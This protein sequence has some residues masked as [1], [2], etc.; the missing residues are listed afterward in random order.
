MRDATP[1]LTIPDSAFTFSH[2]PAGATAWAGR[3]R[4]PGR[5]RESHDHLHLAAH[6]AAAQAVLPRRAAEHEG[7]V[8]DEE[9]RQVPMRSP[10]VTVHSSRG[11]SVIEFAIVL[12][13][14]LHRDA[15]RRRRSATRSST[16]TSSPSSTREGS[17][18][19]SR[20][21]SLADAAA[22]LKSMSGRP[23][24]FNSN[25]EGDLLGGPT[26]RDHRQPTT[27]TRTS[28]TSATSTARM[29]GDQHA[30]DARQRL[31]R[32][33]APEYE[34]Q[35]P[36]SDTSIQVTNL[37]AGHRADPRAACSTSPRSIHDAR[38]DHA[39]RQVRRQRAEDALF[40]CLF[41]G[42][43]PMRHDIHSDRSI[44]KTRAA[45]R[46]STWRRP[47]RSC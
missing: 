15:R 39:V 40:D 30:R 5:H 26:R 27:T 10:A 36:D 25:I 12:P 34:R 17:N 13:L 35:Q 8:D 28:S 24:D 7:R 31:L 18:L 16:S 41:L 14:L 1:T 21:T 44:S 20:E 11:Q 46:S 4:R 37:P 2:M 6:D 42:R 32:F 19:I 33:A 43:E 23:V 29:L 9:R 47:Q 22:A 45:T 38:A 3:H